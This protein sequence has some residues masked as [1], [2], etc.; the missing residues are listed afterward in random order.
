VTGALPGSLADLGP[1]ALAALIVA[2]YLVA[3]E[4]VVGAVLHRRFEDRLRTDPGARRSF[5]RRL[6]VL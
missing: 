5:Y 3:G 4:P 1:A 2:G 6:L